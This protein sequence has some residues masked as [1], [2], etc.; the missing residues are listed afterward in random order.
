MIRKVTSSMTI[1]K[2]HKIWSN[3]LKR[4]L[5][6][7][8]R[9]IITLNS[10]LSKLLFKSKKML[11]SRGTNHKPSSLPWIC[12]FNAAVI[13]CIFEILLLS[14][15]Q[16]EKVEYKSFCAMSKSCSVQNC[17]MIGKICNIFLTKYWSN[18]FFLLLSK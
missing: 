4:T 13:R 14:Q 8:N 3:S 16:F 7:D 1:G 15:M 5:D 11:K 17:T 10:V 6:Y 2:R 9:F 12:W 18:N